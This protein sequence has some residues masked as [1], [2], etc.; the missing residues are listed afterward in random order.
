MSNRREFVKIAGATALVSTLS[1]GNAK[2]NPAAKANRKYSIGLAGYTFNYWRKDVDKVIEV[3]KLA[4]INQATLKDFHLPYDS[5][6]EQCDAIMNKFKAA[7]ISIYGLGV[8]GMKTEESVNNAFK[9]AQLAG[10]KMIIASPTHEMLQTLE[11]SAKEFNIKVAIHN[12]GPEDKFPDIDSIYERIK[13]LDKLIGICLD[14]GHSYRCGND[15]AAMFSKF[16]DRVYDL[17]I[18]DFAEQIEKTPALGLGQGRIDLPSIIKKLDKAGYSG[19]C[20]VEYEVEEEPV[21]AAYGIVESVGYF[22]GLLAG[23]N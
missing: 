13:N 10:V 5:S 6:K 22:R 17:H 19:R 16:H 20:S 18:K 21:K 14:I 1:I 23:I 11:K 9:Y 12:H 4:R 7:G 3:M 15:P 2:P 8:I